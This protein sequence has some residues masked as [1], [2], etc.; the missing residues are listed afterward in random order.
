MFVRKPSIHPRTVSSIVQFQ[1]AIVPGAATGKCL[2]PW[3]TSDAHIALEEAPTTHQDSHEPEEPSKLL[4]AQRVAPLNRRVLVSNSRAAHVELAPYSCPRTSFT[5]FT[6]LNGTPLFCFS[7][8]HENLSKR[9]RFDDSP[10]PTA[11]AAEPESA[12]LSIPWSEGLFSWHRLC[13]TEP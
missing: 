9:W 3:S 1:F 6:N 8:V 12:V 5:S 10:L 11:P 2:S 4:P 7:G 13:R